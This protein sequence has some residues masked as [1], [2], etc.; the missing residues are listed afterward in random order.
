MNDIR[1]NRNKYE[2]L[3]LQSLIFLVSA[4]VPVNKSKEKQI[5]AELYRRYFK[6]GR[7]FNIYKVISDVDKREKHIYFADALVYELKNEETEI[8]I[9]HTEC[10]MKNV[11]SF[12]EYVEQ[13]VMRRGI[14]FDWQ[15]H[16]LGGIKDL[17]EKV[18]DAKIRDNVLKQKINIFIDKITEQRKNSLIELEEQEKKMLEE[19]NEK[20]SQVLVVVQEQKAIMKQE[21]K[22]LE[23]SLSKLSKG[24]L[25]NMV[26]HLDL[27]Y[28]ED[29]KKIM[30]KA[31]KMYPYDTCKKKNW[32]SFV[33]NLE[34]KYP[35][36]DMIQ[37]LKDCF[38]MLTYM[39]FE[40][41]VPEEEQYKHCTSM[42][43]KD[44]VPSGTIEDFI[45]FL[46]N[47]YINE[48]EGGTEEGFNTI[49]LMIYK[50][51]HKPKYY[52]KLAKMVV[53]FNKIIKN[54]Y[55]SNLSDLLNTKYSFPKSIE[56]LCGVDFSTEKNKWVANEYGVQLKDKTVLEGYYELFDFVVNDLFYYIRSNKGDNSIEIHCDKKYYNDIRYFC[57]FPLSI[58]IDREVLNCKSKNYVN[59][60]ITTKFAKDRI[61]INE[62]K[63]LYKDGYSFFYEVTNCHEYQTYYS[64]HM[65][66]L[67]QYLD[68]AMDFYNFSDA[69][70]LKL[71][72]KLK[73]NG[74]DFFGE[75][76]GNTTSEYQKTLGGKILRKLKNE[77]PHEFMLINEYFS[78]ITEEEINDF[79]IYDKFQ[80]LSAIEQLLLVENGVDIGYEVSRKGVKQ[81]DKLVSAEELK[82][83]YLIDYF[84]TL[85]K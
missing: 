7:L 36:I 12:T 26:S 17:I 24:E 11:I 6:D 2:G 73:F 85:Y 50:N 28:P 25:I 42:R 22:H 30:K 71:F 27:Y 31:L 10:F 58:T 48:S 35:K 4:K 5:W 8:P 19:S 56:K 54:H 46:H 16:A 81:G 39:Y 18:R 59:N 65:A 74:N 9:A 69:N 3:P 76:Y 70:D 79:V 45:D 21:L 62:I 51:L 44:L 63:F 47:W 15:L 1:I 67:T 32:D 64:D 52:E 13:E 23:I 61:D 53:N 14:K 72:F 33:Y 40:N 55:N 68:E 83:Q 38:V 66:F 77:C 75:K 43:F 41:N 29:K 80:G 34:F 57:E 82:N 84:K 60:L 78:D 20:K 49:E 37:R